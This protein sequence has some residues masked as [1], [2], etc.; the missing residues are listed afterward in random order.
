[1]EVRIRRICVKSMEAAGKKDSIFRRFVNFS[2][3]I[4]CAMYRKH[5]MIEGPIRT[6]DI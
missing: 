3:Y 1:M 2:F 4:F 6:R 5:D